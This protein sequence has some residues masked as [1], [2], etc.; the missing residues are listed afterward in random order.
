MQKSRVGNVEIRK[1]AVFFFF[2]LNKKRSG[3][4]YM[5]RIFE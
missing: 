1:K 4:A 3:K 5:K 2:F